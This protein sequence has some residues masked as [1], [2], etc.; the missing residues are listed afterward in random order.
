MFSNSG[1]KVTLVDIFNPNVVGEVLEKWFG[2]VL[3]LADGQHTVE[4]LIGFISKQYN[5]APPNNLKE[6]IVSFVE[7]LAA[8]KL[9]VLAKDPTELPYYLSAPCEYLDIEKAKKLLEKDQAN[10]N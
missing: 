5:D 3:Q 8:S 4:E 2:M 7:R 10:L 9:I 1:G 6:T